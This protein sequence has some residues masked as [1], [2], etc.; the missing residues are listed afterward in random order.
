MSGPTSAAE[1]VLERISQGGDTHCQRWHLHFPRQ[2]ESS[3]TL[4]PLLLLL[5]MPPFGLAFAISVLTTYGPVILIRLAH[6]PTKVGLLIGGE[7]A[8]A[9]VVPIAAGALSDRLPPSPLG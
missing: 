6:S 8:F 7:G 9:L 1:S 4:R 5:G 2:D 3:S